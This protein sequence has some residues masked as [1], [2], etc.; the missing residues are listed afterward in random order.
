VKVTLADAL[1]K[2]VEAWNIAARTTGVGMSVA[3]V[4][5]ER[6]R[7]DFINARLAGHLTAILR[8]A[9]TGIAAQAG[10]RDVDMD[11]A[12]ASRVP[13]SEPW[14]DSSTFVVLSNE[15]KMKLCA[16]DPGVFFSEE[17]RRA[18][19]Q[20]CGRT[21]DR[22]TFVLKVV[23]TLSREPRCEGVAVFGCELGDGR[24]IEL[25]SADFVFIS[26]GDRRT[27]FGNGDEPVDIT[28]VSLHEIGHAL[29]LSH[30]SLRGAMTVMDEY[31]H[32]EACLGN[33]VHLVVPGTL[34]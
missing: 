3:S 16:V 1:I 10:L 28:M 19:S 11:M 7:V 17:L 26:H 25:N 18:Q 22:P 13:G 31:P 4:I 9:P 29:G 20:V 8:Y 2:A 5:D 21:D 24:T 12:L 15:L 30:D 32:T 23:E 34:R 6:S 27:L 33:D 14:V